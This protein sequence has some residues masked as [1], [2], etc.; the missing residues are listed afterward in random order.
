MKRIRLTW[1]GHSCFKVEKDGFQV[2]FDPYSDGAVP[3]YG[4]LRA[5]AD[6]VLCSH[7][8]KDHNAAELVTLRQGACGNPFEIT[9]IQ[10]YHDDT[11]G[12][13]RGEDIIHILD[14]EGMRVVH[15]GDL[16]C[17]LTEEQKR[18]IGSPDVILLPVGGYYTIDAGQAK[19]VA[20]GV[21]PRVVIP[22]HYRKGEVGYPVLGTVE[23]FTALYPADRVIG[24]PDNVIEIDESTES[25]IAVLQLPES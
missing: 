6:L 9:K 24:C 4:P 20:D 18:Q 23:E 12:S 1:L 11:E 14:S 25:Q 10:T 2:L 15:F 3:G 8:H 16:G 7:G 5:E 22:M 13:Q 21:N 19:A 17:E